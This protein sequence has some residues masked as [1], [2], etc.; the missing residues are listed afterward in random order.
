MFAL[1]RKYVSSG[2]RPL[3]LARGLSTPT[4]LLQTPKSKAGRSGLSSRSIALATGGT[5]LAVAGLIWSGHGEQNYVEDPR[6]KKAL[7]TVPLP[8]LVS[9]WV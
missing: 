7:S 6:D 8:K 5:C 4:L 2:R 1:G 3:V 9:G